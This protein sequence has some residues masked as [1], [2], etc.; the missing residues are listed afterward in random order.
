MVNEIKI[1]SKLLEESNRNKNLLSIQNKNVD[2]IKDKLPKRISECFFNDLKVI[3]ICSDDDVELFSM[4]VAMVTQEKR[5]YLEIPTQ[6]AWRRGRW[7]GLSHHR[8]NT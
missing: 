1:I 7:F 6:S 3:W 2:Q 4:V 5:P 8:R